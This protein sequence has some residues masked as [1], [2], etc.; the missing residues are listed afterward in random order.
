MNYSKGLPLVTSFLLFNLTNKKA[1]NEGSNDLIEKQTAKY[2]PDPVKYTRIDQI[3]LNDPRYQK[4][5]ETHIL[6]N[7]LLGKNKIEVFEAY[8]VFI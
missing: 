5:M 7:C 2:R 6:H 3:Y 8:K 4:M 1:F